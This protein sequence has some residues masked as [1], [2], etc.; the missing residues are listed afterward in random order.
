MYTV[1]I[2]LIINYSSSNYSIL[3]SVSTVW[4][5]DYY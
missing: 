4:V 1:E 5:N 2:V 3:E